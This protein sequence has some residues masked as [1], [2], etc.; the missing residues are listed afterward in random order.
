MGSGSLE[1]KAGGGQTV[2]Y[3]S[4]TK[5]LTGEGRICKEARGLQQQK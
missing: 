3:T 1:S 2:L 5:N 4:R